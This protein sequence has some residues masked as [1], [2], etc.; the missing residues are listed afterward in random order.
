LGNPSTS[1]D[2]KQESPDFFVIFLRVEVKILGG[3]DGKNID[4]PY[5]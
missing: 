1:H 3:P 2:N 5:E 4:K